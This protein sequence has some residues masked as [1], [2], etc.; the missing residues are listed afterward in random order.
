MRGIPV[1][2]DHLH[3]PGFNQAILPRRNDV[4]PVFFST[5]RKI[6]R[7]SAGRVP[8]TEAM[9]VRITSE[10]PTPKVYQ[11]VKKIESPGFGLE[12]FNAA[13]HR[14]EKEGAEVRQRRR[15]VKTRKSVRLLI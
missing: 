14:R 1:T 4:A 9:I 5:P 6:S 11:G 15:V 12:H 2:I 10:V 3:I 7:S 8:A 13:G